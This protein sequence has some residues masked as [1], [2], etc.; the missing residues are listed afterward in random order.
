MKILFL[1]TGAADWPAERPEGCKEFRRLSSALIDDVLLI[2]PGPGVPDALKEFGRDPAKIRYIINTHPHSDHYCED[3]A[4]ALTAL[5]AEL[6]DFQD[7]DR[8]YAVLGDYT[9]EAFDANHATSPGRPVHFIIADG[10]SRLFYGLDG[11]WLMYDEVQA[12]IRQKPDY[13]VLDATIGDVPG[14][15]R[16]FEH[17]NLNMVREMK[18]TL[19]PYVKRFC[20]SHMA[21]TLH[22]DHAALA[23]TMEKDGI[24]VAFDG[25][26]TRF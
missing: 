22:T 7:E 11:A 9:V 16:I 13:A 19:A 8:R 6:V 21:M 24:E 10:K 3:T 2:D 4:A 5:G 20:I 26:E 14:D 23:R 15:Y 12:I 17:N 25:Y 1:G 18:L